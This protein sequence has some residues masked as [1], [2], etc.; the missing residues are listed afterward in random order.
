[1]PR[2]RT[3]AALGVAA[4]LTLTGCATGSTA[5]G[6]DTQVANTSAEADAFPVTIEH[7]FG[8]TTIEEQPQRVATLGWSDQDHVLALGVA[9]VGATKLTWGGNE[10]GSSDWFDAELERAGMEPPTRYDDADGAPVV[11]IAK[12]DP[13]LILA[14]NS[15]ISEQEYAKLSKIAPVVAYPEHPWITPWQT[16]LE[17]VGTALGRSDLAE[18][19][20]AETEQA[21]DDAA[22]EHPQLEGKSLIFAYLTTTD[23][24]SIGMYAP[25]DP[26][27]SFM[28][29][30]GLV[31]AP[32]VAEA[33]KPGEFYGTVSAERASELESDVLLTWSE[34][35]DDM[36]TFTEH[37]LIGQIPAIANGHAYAEADKHVSLAVT[38]PTPLSIPYVIEHFVPHVARAVAGS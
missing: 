34:N 9:P 37:N 20:A 27:V 15:G 32:S 36:Q 38:N 1:M 16:S 7:A 23:L 3:L 24:S 21:I 12:L 22:A 33:I 26:R 31:D 14:T 11:E 4:A 13:D 2:P 10:A 5:A 29:D 8:E 18:E 19:V 25:Q 35:P 17:M 28:H 6:S 30:L